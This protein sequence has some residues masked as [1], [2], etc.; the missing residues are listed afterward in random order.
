M[1]DCVVHS[2]PGVVAVD[3]A[4]QVVALVRDVHVTLKINGN[5][6]GLVEWRRGIGPYNTH[7]SRRKVAPAHQIVARICDIQPIVG[8]ERPLEPS[9]YF[10]HRSVSKHQGWC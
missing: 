3:E 7:N 9:E 8:I 6:H 1:N 5:V 10:V 4:Q 2:L